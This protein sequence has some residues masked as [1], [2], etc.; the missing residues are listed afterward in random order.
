MTNDNILGVNRLTFNDYGASEGIVWNPTGQDISVYYTGQGGENSFR[1][2]SN[3]TY[4][5]AF[6]GADF[7]VGTSAPMGKMHVAGV[8]ARSNAVTISGSVPGLYFHDSE[9]ASG[10]LRY[11]SFM[12]EADGSKFHIG[13]RPRTTAAT[14]G[15]GS[16]NFTINSDGRVGIMNSSPNQAL[17]VR[18][19]VQVGRSAAGDN[20]R[21]GIEVF[22]NGSLS[23]P[24]SYRNNGPAIDVRDYATSGPSSYQYRGIV[25]SEL[26]RVA[27]GDTGAGNAALFTAF[28]D[29][30][31]SVRIDGKANL[32]VGFWGQAIAGNTNLVVQNRVGIGT[33]TPQ[34]VL[35]VN[36]GNGSIR[37]SGGG[38]DA[39]QIE[40]RSTDPR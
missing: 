13:S 3:S 22:R 12:M 6:H 26:P 25:H 20:S 29:S 40:W 31:A 14:I 10:A 36:T 15:S 1:F 16:R 19:R 30:G 5:F 18:G 32:Q 33:S 35:D 34:S 38:A 7:G 11:S 17:D 28:N 27:T 24:G 4:P 8:D 9:T 2:N 37:L 21:Y 23:S 39:G